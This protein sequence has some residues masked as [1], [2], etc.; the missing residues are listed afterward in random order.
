MTLRSFSPFLLSLI[1]PI[2]AFAQVLDKRSLLEDQTFWANR[3]FEWFEE[4]IPFFDSPDAEINTTYYYRWEL[5]TRH[6]VYGNPNFGYA[7][8]EFANRPF[9]SGAYGTISCP[10]GHQIYEARWLHEPRYVRDYLRFWMRHPGAQPRN[11]SFWVAD[12]AWAAHQVHPNEAF[13]V[14]LLPDLIGNY[15]AWK[16]RQWVEEKGMFWQLGHDDGMEFDINAQQTRDILR[17]G[18]SLRPTFNA[19]MWADAHAI[20]KIAG[21]NDDQETANRFLE[22]ADLIKTQVETHLWDPERQFFFP[23]SNQEHE[24]DG[25]VVE[26]HTLT[27]ETGRFAGSPHGRELHGYVPWAFNMPSPGFEDAWRFLMDEEYFWAPF[28]PTTVEQNDP[29]FVL[30]P[31][32][33]WWSGQSWPFATTQTLKAMANLLQNYEQDH[34]DRDDFASLFHTFAITHRKDG[35]PYIAEAVHPFTGSWDGHDMRNRS[36]HYF[37]SGFTDLVITG[38]AGVQPANDDTFTIKPLVPDDWDY[39]ALDN[40]PYRGHTLSILWDRTGD[41]YGVGPGLHI[42]VNG[43][44]AAT[45]PELGEL[46]VDLPTA[47]IIP[48]DENPPMNF[49]VNNDGN[50]YPR[51]QASFVNP[52]TSLAMLSDGQYRYDVPPANRWT[53]VGSGNS[54]DWVSVDFGIERPIEEVRLYVL[55]DGEGSDVRAPVSIELSYW[56]GEEWRNVPDHETHPERPTGG[57]PFTIRFPTLNTDR[58]RAEVIHAE[59]AGSGLTEFEAW[60]PGERPYTPAP[61][62]EGNLAYNADGEGYPIATASFSDRFG[63]IPRRAI[64]GRIVFEANPVHRWTS[65]GSPNSE[66]WL[67]IEFAEEK[68]VGRAILHIYD[69]RGGVQ[70]PERYTVE[71]WTGT[72]WHEVPGQVKDPESPTGN[73]AN[74]V[75][76]P[77]VSTNKVRVLFTHRGNARSGVTELEIWEQ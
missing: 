6:F 56:N 49:A 32:C 50:Y 71:V 54:R 62:P 18:Q 23:M 29:L 11:Y 73:M 30:Q 25:Y 20:A 24:R 51:Y 65:Y 19:Y 42:L 16:E 7:F 12:S 21:L 4:N 47:R 53:T 8:T 33:C 46:S 44:P 69:D 77:P 10:A 34:I 31:G 75:T 57:R 67:E 22:N 3:D 5:V 40:L 37:H 38:L 41:R 70:A 74:T 28:G 43:E 9:W 45:A 35:K 26:R 63:G 39:F 2:T 1:I 60:G 36:E 68:T 59:G 72:D 13:M 76:F 17:G 48:V 55:D 58:L 14:D 64:D 15:E 66:D 52:N 27:Y 61:P